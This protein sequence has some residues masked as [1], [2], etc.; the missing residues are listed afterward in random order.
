MKNLHRPKCRLNCPQRKNF[1]VWCEGA[2]T[3]FVAA[4]YKKA[5]DLQ[6]EDWMNKSWI[7]EISDPI[8]LVKCKTREDA[9]LAFLQTSYEDYVNLLTQSD[10]YD[11]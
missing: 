2:V 8:E 9:Y 5:A 7:S 10:K 11:K 1:I 3:Q 6:K 4:A